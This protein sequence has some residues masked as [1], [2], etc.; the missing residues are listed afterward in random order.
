MLDL[1]NG[2]ETELPKFDFT[3]GHRVPGRKLK[4]GPEEPII[5]EGIHALNDKLTTS[6]PKNQKFKIFISPQAQINLD[7]HNPLSLTDLRLLR[8][9]VR[10]SKFRSSPAEE[11]LE[12][13]P[14]VRA[15]EF[16]WI[17]S[18]QEGCDY[19]F[20]SFLPYELPVMKKYAMPLLSAIGVESPYYPDA[21]RLLRMLKFF[22]DMPDV[23]VP[24]NS[25]MREFIGGSCYADV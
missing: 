23:W 8:R 2:E 19:V 24:S 25:L 22:T 4:L 14:K 3:V 16:K 13:W 10:D 15:G 1:I 5:I 17:Y 21:E 18:T 6:I 7:D 9:L 20:N 11:T 12:M